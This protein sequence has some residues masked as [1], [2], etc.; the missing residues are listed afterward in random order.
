MERRAD[1]FAPDALRDGQTIVQ[2]VPIVCIVGGD[3]RS[4]APVDDFR[5]ALACDRRDAR[6]AF[7]FDRRAARSRPRLDRDMHRH[8]RDNL[9]RGWN[10][11]EHLIE[12]RESGKAQRLLFS[13]RQWRWRQVGK[14]PLRLRDPDAMFRTRKVVIALGWREDFEPIV[15]ATRGIKPEMIA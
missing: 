1:Q 10:F 14:R 2:R 7:G 4:D 12:P 11:D 9:Y 8:E 15:A 5:A 3:R 6:F 13:F